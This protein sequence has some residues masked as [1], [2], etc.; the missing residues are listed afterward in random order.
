MFSFWPGEK[1]YDSKY[2]FLF[3]SWIKN[4]YRK[5][6][7]KLVF[8]YFIRKKWTPQVKWGTCLQRNSYWKNRRKKTKF[9]PQILDFLFVRKTPRK[10]EESAQLRLTADT[11]YE[12]CRDEQKNSVLIFKKIT[13]QIYWALLVKNPLW[14]ILSR[15]H[16]LPC[17]SF[18]MGFTT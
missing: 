3:F 4:I 9:R 10:I 18:A 2:D 12:I 8:V 17:L 13:V 5:I 14:D 11:S 7:W 1:N 16:I 6:W 15:F